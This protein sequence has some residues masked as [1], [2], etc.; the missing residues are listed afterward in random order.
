MLKDKYCE[1]GQYLT[2]YFHSLGQMLLVTDTDYKLTG[3]QCPSKDCNC[4]YTIEI[5]YDGMEKVTI[6]TL[7]RM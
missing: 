6:V 7:K 5:N 1:C 4:S 3:V 2:K